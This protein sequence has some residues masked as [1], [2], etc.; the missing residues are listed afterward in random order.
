MMMFIQ[1]QL[2]FQ[3]ILQQPGDTFILLLR[4]V[5]L[6]QAKKMIKQLEHNIKQQ[7]KVD[8]KNIGIT[9]F[10]PSDSY[11]SLLDRL[12][13]YYVMSKLS[14]RKKIFYGTLEFNFYET[15]NTND[16]LTAILR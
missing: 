2:E 16:V 4:N 9:L 12:D 8:I 11:K 13:Q 10:D 6:H 5:K 15:P 3:P 14:T 1:T 7:F